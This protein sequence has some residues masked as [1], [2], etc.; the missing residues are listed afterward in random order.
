MEVSGSERRSLGYIKDFFG[1]DC[2][3]PI[4]VVLKE[5]GL[6]VDEVVKQGKKTIITVSQCEKETVDKKDESNNVP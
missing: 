1:F 6:K 2:Y 3:R 4:E 5:V